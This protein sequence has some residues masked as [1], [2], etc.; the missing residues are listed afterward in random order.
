M[1]M[2]LILVFWSRTHP[3]LLLSHGKALISRPDAGGVRELRRG[4][5][6]GRARSASV[7]AALTM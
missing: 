4:K 5:S 2:A 7:G 1:L 6:K 3:R